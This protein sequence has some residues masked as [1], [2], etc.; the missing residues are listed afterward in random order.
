ML[1]HTVPTTLL[2]RA[3]AALALGASLGNAWAFEAPGDGVYK[4]R[5]DWGVM[6]DLSGPTAGNEVPWTRGVQA[7]IRK[8]N[9]AG[10]AH[11]R[12]INLLVEDDRYDTTL[13]RANYERLVTQTNVLAISGMGS[14]SAQAALMPMI[15]AGKVPIVGAYALHKSGYE[16]AHPMYYAG[17]CGTKEMAQSGVGHFS[18]KL[19]LKNPK[20]AVVHLDVAGGK[21]YAD[22]INTEVTRLG[23][24]SKA[25]PMK[26]GAADATSQ[27]LE[28]MSMKP[29]LVTIYGVPSNSILTLRTMAQYGVKI[30]S[31]GIT[32]LGTLEIYTA[33]GAEAG[34]QYHFMSCLTPTDS[35]D[36]P[37]MRE[38]SAAADKYGYGSFK[39]NVNY[40]GGW[41]VGQLIAEAVSKVGPQPTRDKL[42]AML[43]TGISVDTKG[44]SSPLKYTKDDHRGLIGLRAYTFDYGS[45]QFKAF[46]QYGDY[47]KFIK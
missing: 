27:V 2:R 5:I 24:T 44:V 9:E 43:N 21:E 33:L 40:V 36:T 32:H 8:F 14:S 45:K 29:D 1:H 41:V 37:A 22:Y 17:F 42:V 38:M 6:M 25:L 35:E 39:S 31:W 11:G 28:I 12:K 34:A 4:D 19:K 20:I 23:G 26:P 13:V 7:Y 47:E 3:A 16:P 15:K 10:G 18:E 30:P 46:G